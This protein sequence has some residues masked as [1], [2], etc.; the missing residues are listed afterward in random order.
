M[1]H[2]RT[3]CQKRT[4]KGRRHGGSS[5]RWACPHA[6]RAPPLPPPQPSAANP[7]S[8]LLP[9][10]PQAAAVITP[11]YLLALLCLASNCIGKP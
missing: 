9:G 8:R 3:R 4:M 2:D 10:G 1:C 6:P 5:V 7:I 11:H